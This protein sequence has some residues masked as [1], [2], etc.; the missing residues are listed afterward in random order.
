M[1]DFA[2]SGHRWGTAGTGQRLRREDLAQSGA[3]EGG[4]AGAGASPGEAQCE[5]APG[6]GVV[7]GRGLSGPPAGRLGCGAALPS[8]GT[9]LPGFASTE[10][11]VGTFQSGFCCIFPLLRPVGIL[12]THLAVL[13][14][15]SGR[16]KLASSGRVIVS[17]DSH[18]MVSCQGYWRKQAS[19]CEE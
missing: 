19:L 18:E 1:E 15:R 10:F 17:W 11:L 12:R 2:V 7:V 4:R 16:R 3:P 9:L 14:P 6:C 13:V 5:L 8:S